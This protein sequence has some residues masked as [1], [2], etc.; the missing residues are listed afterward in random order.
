MKRKFFSMLLMG[1]MAIASVGMFTSC[2]DY[3]DDI[4]NL[5]KQID[6]ITAQN[7]QSQLTTLQNALSTAQSAADAAKKGL[8]L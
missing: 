8:G 7:L 3:D 1:A 5:Q 6:G 2:K 4:N